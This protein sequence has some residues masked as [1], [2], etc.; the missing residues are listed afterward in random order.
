MTSTRKMADAPSYRRGQNMKWYFVSLS[1]ATYG[2][3]VDD[4]DIVRI[5]APIAR[6]MIG[7]NLSYVTSWVKGKNG[8]IKELK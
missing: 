1:Y 8:E 2:I 4:G 7:R 5:A 3:A 6:W